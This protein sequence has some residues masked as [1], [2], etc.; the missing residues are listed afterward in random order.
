MYALV[1]VCVCARAY[2]C[3]CVWINSNIKLFQI[4]I[5]TFWRA[6]ASL[7]FCSDSSDIYSVNDKLSDMPN[8][9][10]ISV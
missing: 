5:T 10:G 6:F 8:C 1:C 3:A 2:I 9:N 4:Q 7:L